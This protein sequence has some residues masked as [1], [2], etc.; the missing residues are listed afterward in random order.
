MILSII[1]IIVFII[2]SFFFSG[3]ETGLISINKLSLEKKANTNSK[4]KYLLDFVNNP[5]KVLGTTLIGTNISLVI[6]ASVFTALVIKY[7]KLGLS[8]ISST[9]IISGILLIFAEIIPKT[10]F[11]DHSEYL[12][13]KLLPVLK[14]FNILFYPLIKALS[15]VNYL[16]LGI[17]GIKH[18]KKTLFT[19]DDIVFLISEAEKEGE[20]EKSEQEMI[21]EVLTFRELSAKNVMTPRTDI[22]AVQE[23]DT[24]QSVIELSKKEGLTRF[25]VY[26]KDIDHIEG[27]LIIY[28]LLKAESND[29]KVAKYKRKV[30]FV[31]ESMKA[32]I[33]LKRMRIKKTPLVIVVD[34]YGGTAGLVTI[35]DLLEE[36]V[37]EIED[38]YDESEIEIQKITE[39]TYMVFGEVEIDYLNDNYG[40]KLPKKDEYETVAGL[41]INK[42]ARIPKVNE[43]FVIDG[44][45]LTIKQAT[46]K[47]I[48]KV[49][50]KILFTSKKIES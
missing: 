6:V 33:L 4:T 43:K 39:N 36:L 31:P 29:E 49:M 2:L 27:V 41:I 15:K 10:L 47:K 38:E 14:F 32:S 24:I 30:H 45:E 1:I 37:G 19:K 40:F 35:E 34:E 12:I 11:R 46:K 26:S 7:R 8:E 5:D 42:I 17:F 48:E 16:L 9:L 20:V 22:I 21:H 18:T 23:D 3:C 13:P 28:D 50:I 25:P 44:Y